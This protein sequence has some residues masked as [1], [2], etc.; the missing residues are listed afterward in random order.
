MGLNNI[1]HSIHVCITKKTNI[2]FQLI[3]SQ[4][5]INKIFE[6][7]YIIKDSR[8]ERQLTFLYNMANNKREGEGGH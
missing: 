3:V 6:G 7:V 2:H 4:K 1:R 8:L 5:N